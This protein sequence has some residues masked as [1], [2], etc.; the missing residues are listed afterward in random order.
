M[1]STD[2][3]GS[4]LPDDEGGDGSQ[5]LAYSSLNNET[6]LLVREHLIQ[7]TRRESFKLHTISCCQK[8][9]SEFILAIN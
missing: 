5:T 6:R 2:V 9:K 7:F 8:Q 3:Y 1:T 4:Q